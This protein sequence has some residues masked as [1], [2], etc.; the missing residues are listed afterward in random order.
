MLHEDFANLEPTTHKLQKVKVILLLPRCSGLGVSNPI[1][2]ILKE[3]EGNSYKS[4]SLIKIKIECLIC[5]QP[6]FA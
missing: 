3:H 4:D 5:A 1:E 6:I 2:F